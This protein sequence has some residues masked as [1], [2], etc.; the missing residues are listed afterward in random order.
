ME[1]HDHRAKEASVHEDVTLEATKVDDLTKIEL[2]Q[3]EN[4]VELDQA[5]LLANEAEHSLKF[6]QAIQRYPMATLWAALM[7]FTIIVSSQFDLIAPSHIRYLQWQREFFP[8]VVRISTNSCLD[9]WKGM[10]RF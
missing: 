3:I 6:W 10:T 2:E 7:S 1:M 9:R 5:M 4:A 8:G